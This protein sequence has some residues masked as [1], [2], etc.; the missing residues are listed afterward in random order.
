MEGI[1]SYLV[2]HRR[3]FLV[4]LATLFLSFHYFVTIYVGSSL[5]APYDSGMVIEL[6][7]V[8]GASLTILALAFFGPL[9][10]KFGNATLLLALALLEFGAV[11]VLAYAESATFIFPAFLLF[12][13]IPPLILFSLDIFLENIPHKEEDTG[14]LRGMALTVM[15]SAL[16]LSP[17]LIGVTAFDGNFSNT[18]LLANIFL[19]PVILLAHFPLRTFPEPAYKRESFSKAFT[20]LERNGGARS[21]TVANLLLQI[22]YAWM[23]VYTPLHLLA[24]GFSW[25]EISWTFSVMLLPF[26]LFELPVGRLADKY[27][28]EKEFMVAGFAILAAS[29]ALLSFIG[30][31]PILIWAGILFVTRLG[32]SFVEITTESYFFKQVDGK[33]AELIGLFRMTRPFSFIAGPIL[34]LL[35]LSLVP[36]SS[37][38]LVFGLILS[39]GVFFSLSLVDTK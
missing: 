6:L 22:F 13:A 10:R 17:L 26:L 3:Y 31:A 5:L 32:A 11:L 27:F 8:A 21:V 24:L 34:G 25:Q 38:F 2:R 7:Y 33:D 18:F 15:N 1:S 36:L 19:L 23:V 16:V 29:T 28:G 4:Y 37:A 20:T 35:I 14:K 39:F 9:L 30:D 12:Q